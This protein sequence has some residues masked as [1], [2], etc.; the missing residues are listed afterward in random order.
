MLGIDAGR[1][2][3]EG[4]S[5]NDWHPSFGGGIFYAPFTRHVIFEVAVGHSAEST[6]FL[7]QSKMLG[8][9]F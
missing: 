9:G 5:S 6:F 3:V 7:I 4:E 8:L 2:F 1:V